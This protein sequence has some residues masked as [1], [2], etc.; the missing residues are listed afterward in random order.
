EDILKPFPKKKRCREEEASYTRRLR[1]TPILK[2]KLTPLQNLNN[3]NS[4][5]ARE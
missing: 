2:W 1:G 4:L 3:L 5:N